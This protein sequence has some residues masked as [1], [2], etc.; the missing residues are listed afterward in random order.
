MG[1]LVVTGELSL[2]LEVCSP[3]GDELTHIY[4]TLQAS[5]VTGQAGRVVEHRSKLDQSDHLKKK[6]IAHF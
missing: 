3:L 4:S 5:Q 1:A 6:C 2:M